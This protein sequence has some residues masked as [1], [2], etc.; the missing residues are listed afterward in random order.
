MPTGHR[1]LW[2]TDVA[3]KKQKKASQK[4]RQQAAKS[5]IQRPQGDVLEHLRKQ[6]RF[7]SSSSQGYDIGDID[8]ARRIASHI[9]AL[10]HDTRKSNSILGQLG[11]KNI[12]FYDSAIPR[13]PGGLM[14]YQGLVGMEMSFNPQWGWM[15]YLFIDENP[16]VSWNSF[17]EWWNAI[18]LDD[19]HGIVFTRRDIVLSVCDQD[20]GAH[21]DKELDEPYVKL[22]KLKQFAF[23]FNSN[24]IERKPRVGAGLASVRQIGF[25]VLMTLE[26]EFPAFLKGKYVRPEQDA[27]MGP[28]T[29]FIGG[30][31]MVEFDDPDSIPDPPQNK[32][33]TP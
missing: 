11:K 26:K 32:A 33:S 17:E 10:V 8:E 22:E 25:E 27:V 1:E 29:M 18:I 6:I 19:L 12:L 14:S 24:G 13:E 2:E 9:R 21:V 15:P 30:V 5:R 20:G 16:A 28:G 4:H 3:T 23:T 7:I 31:Q